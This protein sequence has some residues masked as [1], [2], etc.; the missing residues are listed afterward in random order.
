M[1]RGC[2]DLMNPDPSVREDSPFGNEAENC[3][4]EG[5]ELD[6]FITLVLRDVDLNMAAIRQKNAVEPTF[7]CGVGNGADD[8]VVYL[9]PFE[10]AVTH[11]RV[12]LAEFGI[13]G[14]C[15]RLGVI[16]PE[17]LQGGHCNLLW[18]DSGCE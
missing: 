15:F 10:V 8:R 11:D 18:H 14:G 1:V 6:F 13:D 16:T 17:E 3:F 4:L 9:I 7:P 2:F 12:E 5:H